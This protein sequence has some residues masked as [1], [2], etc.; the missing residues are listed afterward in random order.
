MIKDWSQYPIQIHNGLVTTERGIKTSATY[1]GL[2][3]LCE[4]VTDEG[5]GTVAEIGSY[6]GEGT[7][8]FSYRFKDVICVDPWINGYDKNDIS[9]NRFD[10]EIVHTSFLKRVE[11]CPNIQVYYCESTDILDLVENNSLTL[12]YIDAIHQCGPVKDE[13]WNW[14]KKVNIDGYI[15]GHDFT[16]YWG[17]VVDAIVDTIGLPDVI[18][19]D[20]SWIKAKKSIIDG[21]NVLNPNIAN[22]YLKG[23]GIRP[24]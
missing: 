2:K 11:S 3:D 13:L 17:E 15:G 16:G 21:T 23:K 6:A 18:F 9:S 20:K 7:I 8:L 19:K 10:M 5:Q 22:L 12:A 1:Q 4:Y 24:R 14:I